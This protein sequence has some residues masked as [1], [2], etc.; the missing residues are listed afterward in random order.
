MRVDRRTWRISQ[1]FFATLQTRMKR[2]SWSVIELL[3]S[4]IFCWCDRCYYLQTGAEHND[5]KRPRNIAWVTITASIFAQADPCFTSR[6]LHH[7]VCVLVRRVLI[8]AKETISFVMFVC[9]SFYLSA[10]KT[11]LPRDIFSW[12]WMFESFSKI[13]RKYS[14]FIKIGQEYRLLYI[15]TYVHL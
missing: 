10:W 14:I 8:V 13:Y 6:Q 11:Q 1:S 5:N 2:W 15:K 12:N 7:S 3:Y 4:F 9:L